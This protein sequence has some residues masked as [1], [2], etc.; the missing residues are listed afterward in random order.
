MRTGTLF[1]NQIPER[2]SI[3]S[4]NV[5]KKVLHRKLADQAKRKKLFNKEILSKTAEASSNN[6]VLSKN[7][8]WG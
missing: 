5:N 7:V 4:K 3:T 6:S 1:K 2:N 8:Q